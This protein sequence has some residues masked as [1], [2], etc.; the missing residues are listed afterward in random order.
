MKFLAPPYPCIVGSFPTSNAALM[1]VCARLCQ[2]V[3]HSVEQ[4][5]VHEYEAL[6]ILPLGMTLLLADF[7]HA[8]VCKLKYK[9]FLTVPKK[10]P[11][12]C[13]E[14]AAFS[15]LRGLKFIFILFCH[16]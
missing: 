16:P 6:W 10:Q 3:W 13:G 11:C 4:Q 7:M 2:V 9:K 12:Y 15:M 1:P 5:E 8:R 14:V